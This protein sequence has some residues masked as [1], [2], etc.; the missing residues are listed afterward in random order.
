MSRPKVL[1]L[2]PTTTTGG[3]AS[4]AA[5]LRARAARTDFVVEDTS[6]RF[7]VL[8][9]RETPRHRWLAGRAAVARV[10][11]VVRR[12]RA[13]AVDAVYLT[14]SPGLGFLLRDLVLVLALRALRVP[15][16]VHLHGGDHAG[17][18]GA[19]R[20][21]QR[22]TLAVLDRAALVIAITRPIERHL[23]E[24]LTR[25]AVR[26]VPN[27]LPDGHGAE[28]AGRPRPDGIRTGA[29][30]ALVAW[31]APQ[32]GTFVALRALARLPGDVRLRLVGQASAENAAA[33]DA[34]VADLGLTG[35]VV[36]TGPLDR[37]G[38]D[39]VLARTDVLLLPSATEGFPMVLLEAMAHG[40]PIVATRV[41]AVAEILAEDRP[42]RCGLVIPRRS[43]D[44]SLPAEP[45]DLAGAVR[46]L[47]T[48]RD[49]AETLGAAGRR[50][51][52][53]RYRASVVLPELE[54][55]IAT[56]TSGRAVGRRAPGPADP[57]GARPR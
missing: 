32:K 7:A 1:L 31:Q 21:R 8:G 6:R 25:A 53:D 55:L 11:R 12:A 26:Y 5:I 18:F 47:L 10:I 17:F 37:A 48:D 33:I 24:R 41:G 9:A 51:L 23:A 44:P 28:A 35:R 2:A 43:G 29:E 42:D 14:S 36:V 3:I 50:R 15:V 45:A 56:V 30:L 39:E 38:V 27:M 19:G 40:V 16:V 13:E 46:R 20:A 4:W 49:L 54:D 52:A 22:L 57:V 34:M